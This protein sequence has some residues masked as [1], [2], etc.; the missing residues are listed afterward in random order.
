[1]S[2]I[3]MNVQIGNIHYSFR[4][5]SVVQLIST[6]HYG[7]AGKIGKYLQLI[8]GI[9]SKFQVYNLHVVEL[10]AMA[11]C[12]NPPASYY[13][14]TAKVGV[15]KVTQLNLTIEIRICILWHI[16][17]TYYIRKLSFGGLRPVYNP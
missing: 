13:S 1:M 12:Q 17:L 15:P 14:P 8:Q 10:Q 4:W 3:W 9:S 5:N 16:I 11:S 7:F 2:E 6:V